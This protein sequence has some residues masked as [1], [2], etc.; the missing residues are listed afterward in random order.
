MTHSGEDSDTAMAARTLAELCHAPPTAI[1]RRFGLPLHE[2]TQPSPPPSDCGFGFGFTGFTLTPVAQQHPLAPAHQ[3]RMLIVQPSPYADTQPYYAQQQPWSQQAHSDAQA[4]AKAQAAQAPVAQAQAVLVRVRAQA[5]AQSQALAQA[6]AQAQVLAQAEAQT[7]VQAHSLTQARA[8]AQ[9]L[10]QAQT[11]AEAQAQ[12]LAQAYIRAAPGLHGEVERIKLAAS[13]AQP[14]LPQPQLQPQLQLTLAP[15]AALPK[16][17][18]IQSADL[19]LPDQNTLKSLI[20][21]RLQGMI[22]AQ[23]SSKA[24]VITLPKAPPVSPLTFSA[25]WAACTPTSQ[26][27]SPCTTKI[28][29][30]PAGSAAHGSYCTE[31]PRSTLARCLRSSTTPRPCTSMTSSREPKP[32]ARLQRPASRFAA[33]QSCPAVH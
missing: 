5:Q 9:A 15:R 1:T 11:Q 19:P 8:Q 23:K 27:P 31:R 21:S 3:R 18:V 16:A 14:Q 29:R 17:G 30:S 25:P 32:T 22:D 26:P 28:A 24:E 4:Q 7:E 10:A 20:K 13:L 33:L 6:R 12:A 2:R